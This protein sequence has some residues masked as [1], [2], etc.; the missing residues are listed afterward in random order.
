M[1]LPSHGTLSILASLDFPQ[2]SIER[3]Q[4]NDSLTYSRRQRFSLIQKSPLGSG[5]ARKREA[6]PLETR[7]LRGRC[8]A[9]RRVQMLLYSWWMPVRSVSFGAQVV[10]GKVVGEGI[11]S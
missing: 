2:P 1:P 10:V 6:D 11:A 5:F 9:C 3:N 4:R 7:A 8:H